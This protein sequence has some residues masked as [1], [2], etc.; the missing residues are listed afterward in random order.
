MTRLAQ[1]EAACRTLNLRVLELTREVEVLDTLLDERNRILKAIPC[2]RHGECVP[3]AMREY[4][5]LQEEV[6]ALKLTANT[7][8]E[9][10]MDDRL[11]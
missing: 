10:T 2:P 4:Y 5:R 3:F 8:K 9:T 6:A 1:A 7:Q 11:W